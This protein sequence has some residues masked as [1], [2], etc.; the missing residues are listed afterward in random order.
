MLKDLHTME[1]SCVSTNINCSS[2]DEFQHLKKCTAALPAFI[3][4]IFEYYRI[5][6]IGLPWVFE[7]LT[8]DVTSNTSEDNISQMK[9]A[10]HR[11]NTNGNCETKRLVMQIAVQISE[12]LWKQVIHCIFIFEDTMTL[13]IFTFLNWDLSYTSP[14]RIE[15]INSNIYIRKHTGIWYNWQRD[16][17]DYNITLTV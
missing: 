15:T 4:G 13:L 17:I 12:D 1:T 2:F 6:F 5:N 7:A 11:W 3:A 16:E 8:C 14:N 9:T 10:F